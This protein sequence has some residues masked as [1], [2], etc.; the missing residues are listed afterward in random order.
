MLKPLEGEIS[1]SP[2]ASFFS[3]L[4]FLFFFFLPSSTNKESYPPLSFYD[5]AL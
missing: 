3:A 5:F 1:H 4:Q 2:L